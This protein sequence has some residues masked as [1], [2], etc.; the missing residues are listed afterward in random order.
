[1]KYILILILVFVSTL[2]YSQCNLYYSYVDY[3]P[4]TY[5][6]CLGSS[7]SFNATL[8]TPVVGTTYR[9]ENKS[10]L[11][12]S[13]TP[14]VNYTFSQSGADTIYLVTTFP[15]C[16]EYD[17]TL[18]FYIYNNPETI[19]DLGPNTISMCEG[20][21]V[22]FNASVSG[23]TS[24]LWNTNAT[25]ANITVSTAGSYSVSVTNSCGTG[26]DTVNVNIKPDPTVNLGGNR[27][28][29]AGTPVVLDAGTTNAIYLWST[30]ETTQTISVNDRNVS[31]GVQVDSSGCIGG[32]TIT[33]TDCPVE[34]QVPNAFS[35]NGD[36]K[37]EKLYV[38]GN[39]ISELD[40]KIFNRLGNKVYHSTS[41]SDGWDGSYQGKI[42]ECD[43]YVYIL[44]G[45]LNDGTK[46]E[47]SGSIALIK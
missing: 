19:L 22:D 23:A 7:Q 21:T 13:N 9:W 31:I 36:G 26:R 29:C 5:T 40:L 30:G 34:A 37:N 47:K 32:D 2:L 6:P 43:V 27:E 11:T 42:Q 35:P 4:H 16:P 17:T 44:T 28:V 3:S 24:Y 45:K 33:I 8:T 1:M 15:G 14:S 18:T 25:T 38:R 10:H 41:V 46:F 20:E 39:N 12:I